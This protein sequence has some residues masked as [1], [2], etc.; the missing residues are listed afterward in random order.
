MTTQGSGIDLDRARKRPDAWWTVLVVDPVA[1]R[2]LPALVHR[3]AV[4][5]DRL[6]ITSLVLAL[7]AG[8][9]F[10]DQRYVL[11][12]VLFELHFLLDCLDGKLARVRGTQSPRGGF[13]DVASDLVGTTY[14]LAAIGVS[15]FADEQAALSLL[16]AVLYAVY[17]CS[18]LQRGR[19]GGLSPEGRPRSGPGWLARRGMVATPYGVEAETLALFLLPLVGSESLLRAGLLLT[20]AFYVLATARNLVATYRALPSQRA[21]E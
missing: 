6:S 20:A 7:C 10:L 4:T 14:C 11:G 12:A 3:R 13:L 2:I 19:Y 9:A 5:P 16:P 1:L 15:A 8:T 18:T 17:T 21:P